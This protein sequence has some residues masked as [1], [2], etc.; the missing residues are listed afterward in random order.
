MP[1]S[2]PTSLSV[3][4]LEMA[5]V[6]KAFGATQALR[7][8]SL[9]VAP[10]E[11]HALIGEN[12]AGK[13]TLMKILSGAYQPDAGSIAL[14][15]QPFRPANPLHARECGIAMIYQ[16]LNL[17][18]HLSVE[19]NIL[20]GEEPA[21]FGWLDRA[22]RRDL[23]RRALEELHHADLA[24]Q[25]LV[26][27]ARALVR[28][29]KVLI[30][31]EP[32]SSLTQVDTENL[33]RVI[34]RLRARG[35]SVIYISHF[36]EECQ[37]VCQRYTVLRDG[38]TVGTGDMATARVEDIIRL[39]VG[40]EM[41]DIY[42]RTP[43]EP[44]APVLELKELAGR[45]KPRRVSLQL[46]AGEILGLAGLIGAGRTETARAVFGLDELAAGDV[47]VCANSA[48]DS[49]SS[50][51]QSPIVN[52]QPAIADRQSAIGNRQSS[53]SLLT[54]AATRSPA[55]SLRAGLGLL[56]E[57]RKEEGLMLNRSL[58]DNL[59]ATR[60][61]PFARFGLLSARRQH[62]A[63]RDWMTRL[64]VRARGPEQ[65]IGELSGGNQ[66]KIALGRLLHHDARILLLD[67]PTRGIDVGSKAQIYRL[68]GELAAQ[69]KAVDLRLAAH[70]NAAQG[71]AV[72][73]IS[74]YLPEL[75]GVCDTIGVMCRG[76]LVATRPATEWT[77]HEIIAAAIGH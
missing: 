1:A 3:P 9:S 52:R 25:Q 36:L 29:P 10:G 6:R 42:P 72:L 22:K 17:A 45:V 61:G 33:F 49:V 28:E 11:A 75:L 69:G 31:D 40:R 57:N 53:Q 14:D 24:Q 26:E 38:E 48:A 54:S 66:Q 71:K 76:E 77:E 60:L 55:D 27:I 19:E 70:V 23:A 34:E 16:E 50:N 18:P 74:S 20:L 58:A 4:R 68:I 62:A 39:M 15:G 44:G 7:N 8:V 5:G 43:H 73:F 56:S 67:E 30:M 47:L 51:R 37:R 46:R 41:K 63:T 35:V 65:P 12:G 59:T 13:S 2:P 32:T 21:R 64:D